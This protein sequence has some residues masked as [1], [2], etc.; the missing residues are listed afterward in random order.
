MDGVRRQPNNAES[1]GVE[2]PIAYMKLLD[3][4]EILNAQEEQKVQ[5]F[6]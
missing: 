5:T 3:L 2:G 4:I 1:L 6:S